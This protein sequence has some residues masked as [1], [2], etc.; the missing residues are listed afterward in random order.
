MTEL[1]A[2]SGAAE[3]PARRPDGVWLDPSPAIPAA[4]RSALTNDET[5]V[6]ALQTPLDR[7][8]AVVVVH[9]LFDAMVRNDEHAAEA[10]ALKRSGSEAALPS[11][12]LRVLLRSHDYTKLAGQRIFRD[13][14]VRVA[15]PTRKP[16]AACTT[17]ALKSATPSACACPST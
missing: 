5:P 11:V 17:P 6:V 16:T 9:R 8:R 14:N 2:S 7:A 15:A 3:Q 4:R 1:N 13:E 10:L 12:R